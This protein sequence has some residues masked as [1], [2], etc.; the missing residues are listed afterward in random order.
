[1]TSAAQ[2]GLWFVDTRLGATP[3]YHV[4][5]A[6]RIVGALDLDS[7]R[8]AWTALVVRHESL[9][10]TLIAQDGRLSQLIADERAE[11]RSYTERGPEP[12]LAHDSL[13]QRWIAAMAPLDLATGPLARL[14]VAKV[15]SH[16]HLVVLLLHQAVTDDEST[17]VLIDELGSAYAAERVGHATRHRL[18]PVRAQYADFARWQRHRTASGRFRSLTDWWANTLTPAPPP[19]NLPVDRARTVDPNGAH[20]NGAHPNGAHPNGAGHLLAFDWGERIARPL[21]GLCA[22]HRTTPFAAV[23]TAFQALLHRYGGAERVAVTVPVPVR[24][25]PEFAR[26]VG[27]CREPVVVCTDIAGRP[28][29][30]ELLLRVMTTTDDALRHR[31][32]PFDQLVS[33][34]GPDRDPRVPPL[35]DAAFVYRGRPEPTLD[36]AGADVRALP[37]PT[38]VV[39]ADVTLT[40]D[41]VDPVVRGALA[42]RASMFERSSVRRILAQFHTLLAGA[43]ADPDLPVDSLPLD[44]TTAELRDAA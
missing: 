38:T 15:A 28:S 22:A 23:L 37:V 5:R 9:R 7:L 30:R 42:V 43:L 26:I 11:I 1:V 21:A 27:A 14:A 12:S 29:F 17:A 35:S 41:G 19:L 20:P 40:V 16:E 34:L 33:A 2:D 6:Y 4:R 3:A 31:G 32:L 8:A 24:S 18:P 36:L 39:G 44:D 13:A 25:R 10:T